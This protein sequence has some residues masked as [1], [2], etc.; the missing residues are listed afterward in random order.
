MTAG[1][2]PQ[3][4]TETEEDVDFVR[5]SASVNNASGSTPSTGPTVDVGHTQDASSAHGGTVDGG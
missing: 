1:E 3:V 4:H 5:Q 2:T